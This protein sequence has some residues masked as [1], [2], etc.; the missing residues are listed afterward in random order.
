MCACITGEELLGIVAKQEQML[1]F[2]SF[3]NEE[4]LSI[5]VQIAQLARD[6]ERPIALR[7]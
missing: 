4:A 3:T 1:R 5:G 2:E 6:S 7:I